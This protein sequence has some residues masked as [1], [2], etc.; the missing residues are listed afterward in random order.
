MKRLPQRRWAILLLA[1]MS[2]AAAASEESSPNMFSLS[3]FGTLGIAH[4][5]ATDADFVSNFNQPNGAGFTHRWSPG[6][7]SKLGLQLD[8]HFTQQWSA[9]VQVVAQH[10]YDNHYGP[11]IEWANLKYQWTPDLSVRAGRTV[12]DFF[13]V[14]DSGLVSYTYPWVRPPLEVYGL[15]PVNHKDGV[16][17]AYRFRL[18][19]ASD[20]LRASYGGNTIKI[21]GGGESTGRQ[22]FYVTDTL[23]YEAATLRIGYASL[24]LDYY[25]PDIEG[26]FEGLTSFGNELSAIPGLGAAGA[27]AT[28][29]A[30]R[31][32]LAG[33]PFRIITIGASFDPG[34]WLL[35]AEWTHSPVAQAF[36][37]VTAW[38][39]TA[40]Y[41]IGRF[42]PYLTYAQVRPHPIVEPGIS[43]SGLPPA[44]AQDATGL[45]DGLSEV[46]NA[47]AESQKNLSA[48]VRWDFV[49][50]AA[51]KLQVERLTT[52]SNSTGLLTNVQP[53]FQPGDGATVF[54]ATIDFVL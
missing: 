26:L 47:F 38:Y 21:P 51:L 34:D 13:M 45:S 16:D 24:K 3:G 1:L 49:R 48:G 54:S 4:S 46:L 12:S 39:V 33:I 15:L 29:L 17:V 44:L 8:A 11:Q 5:S 22:F 36:C 28:G 14:S 50:N 18:A 30:N 7:D 32:S 52:G 6:V 20:S 35:M 25:I 53:G 42:T 41:R 9:V 40:G 31:Y 2:S 37:E 27:Q 43:V 10:Q 19:Q 23:E